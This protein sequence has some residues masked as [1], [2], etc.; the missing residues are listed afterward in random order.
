M[1]SRR[2]TRTLIVFTLWLVA[3]FGARAALEATSL[4]PVLR[5]SAPH[6]PQPFF[7]AVSSFANC[8]PPT[9]SN[10][11]S[12]AKRSPSPIRWCSSC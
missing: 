4:T 6:A 10:G 11:G 9:N 12:R 5:V 1:T 7:A 2:S 8:A 3:F